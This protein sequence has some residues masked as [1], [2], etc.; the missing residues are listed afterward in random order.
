MLELHSGPEA[1]VST[2]SY[3]NTLAVQQRALAATTGG[4]VDAVNDDIRETA[5]EIDALLTAWPDADEL[6][7]RRGTPPG[8]D[9]PT[10]ASGTTPLPRSWVR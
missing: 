10:S 2:K 6:A 9:S 8:P 3:L 4:S 7:T 5:G 1:T